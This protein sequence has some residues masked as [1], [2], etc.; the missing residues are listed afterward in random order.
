MPRNPRRRRRIRPALLTLATATAMVV[1]LPG[2]ATAAAGPDAPVARAAAPAP[3]PS[4]PAPNSV[5]IAG[6]LQSELGCAGDWQPACTAT[7]LARAADGSY[8]ADWTLPAGTYQFKVAINHSW[9]TN[10]GAGGA[11]GGDNI[12][13]VLAGP[14][15][16]TFRYDPETHLVSMTPTSLPSDRVTAQ[17]R[18]LAGTS[19]RRNSSDR[20]YFVM[21][22][23]FA[24]GDPGNDTGGYP[25]P[26]GSTPE[27]AKR[28]TGLDPTNAGFYHG[29]DLQ[30][31]INKLDYI[32]GLGSTAIWLT[33]TFKNRPVQGSGND[34]SAGYHGYWITDFTQIDPHLGSN[35]DMKRLIDAAHAKGMKVYF[36]IITNH[37]ADVI[38]YQQGAERG[39][40]YIDKAAAPYRDAAGKPFDDR[41]Y[42]AGDTFPELNRQSFPYTPQFRKPGDETV[43]VPAWLNDPLRYHNRGNAAF[44]GTEGDQYGDFSGLDDLFT[45]QPTV[46]DGMIDIY[47]YWAK[48]GVD[49]FRIDTVKHVNTE[50]WQK[51][52]P[53]VNKAAADAGK[54]DFF[55]FGEVYESDPRKLAYY[56]TTAKLPATLDFGFQ[57]RAT[58]FGLSQPTS[59]LAELYAADDYYTDT[60]SNAYALP[61][62]LGNHDM[63]RIGYFLNSGGSF[64]DT[65]LLQR[66]RLVQ[67]LMF[68]TRGQPITYYGDEQ[69]FTGDGG[70][71]AARQDMFA[72]KVAAYNDDKLIGS[73]GSTATENYNTKAPL[74]SEIAALSA[75]RQQ[76]PALSAG[77]QIPRYSSNK[78][79]VFAVSR[80]AADEQREYVVAANNADTAQQ[81][82]FGVY[83]PNTNYRAIFGADDTVR[84]GRGGQFTVTVPPLSTVVYRADRKLAKSTSAPQPVFTTAAG[85]VVGDR[86]PVGVAVPAGGF[87]QVSFAWRPAGTN[88]W[89]P[90]GVDDNPPYRV[91]PDLSGV[92]DG[93]VVE[94]RAV[95]RD[96]SGNL[97]ATSSSAVVGT[98]PAPPATGG[99]AVNDPPETQ[100]NSVT[101][102]GDLNTEMGCSGDWQPDCGAAQLQLDTA[103]G[104]WKGTFTLP[105]GGTFQYKAA[106][107]NSWT[108]NYGAGG[109][110]N[111][112]NISLTVPASGRVTFY[113]DPGS[114]VVTSDAEGPIVTAPGSAQ[115]ELGCAADW[116]PDCLR[117]W[118]TDP[119]GDGVYTFSTS[120]IPPGSYE[121][122]VAE[123]LSWDV[124]YGAG[125]EPGGANIGYTVSAG[126]VVTFSYVASTHVLTVTASASTAADLGKAKGQWISPELVAWKAGDAA[127][128]PETLSYRL[129]YAADGGMGIDRTGLTGG[130]WIPLTRDPAGLPTG[131][132]ADHPNLT[133]Y[134]ALRL[135][136]DVTRDKALLRQISSGQIA[137]AAF[138][139]DGTLVDAT[140]VQLPLL[141]DA[142]YAK[143][144]EAKLGPVWQGRVPR[145]SVW[146]PTAREVSLLVTPT[147][148]DQQSVPMR[149]GPDGVWFTVG[150]P[151][152]KNAQYRFAVTVYVPS[153]DK[154]V[155]NTVTDPYS[156]A[157]TTNSTASVL[158]DLNDP[159][160]TPSGWAQQ[161]K[162]ALPQPS[163]TS[164]YELSVR[165]FSATDPSVPEQQRGTYLAFTD[166][167]TNGMKHLRA[168][169]KAGMN[170]LHLLPAFD[171]A[172]VNEN[173][174]T[175]KNPPCDL[176]ALSAADPAGEQQQQCVGSVTESDAFNWGYDPLHYT[177]PEGSYATDP[178]GPART[179]QFRQ[180][181]QGIN[182]AGLRVVMDV[183][184]N[185]TSASGQDDK[186]VLDKLVPGYYHRL[187]AEGA[188]ETS[189]CCA[190]TATEH[191][192]M[193]KLTVDSVVTWAKQYKVD[194]FRF[195]LMGHM[196]KQT[197]LDVRAALDRLT[198][199]RDGVDGKKV[200]LY[201]EGWN[202]GEVADDA[203]FEQATQLNMGGT[204]IG[205][206]ND[207]LRD[208]VRGG[209]PFD[210]NPG[211]QGFGTG[212][213]TDPNNSGANGSPAQQRAALLADTDR[214]KVALT[215]NLADY[216]LVDAAGKLV[217]GKDIDY[218]GAPTGYA[219]QPSDTINYVD[220]HDNDTLYDALA[221]K[222]PVD[223][224]MADRVRM[225]TLSLATATLSQAPSFWHAGTD[226]LRS[227]SFD[228]NSYNS[229]DWF[230]RIDW[231]GQ[232][233]TFGSGLPL[234]AD[235]SA[236]WDYQRPLLANRSLKPDAAAMQSAT[237]QA[238]EL[239]KLRY[240]SPLFRLGNAA[241]IQQKVSF[242]TAGPSTP[243]GVIA[244]QLDDRV[245]TAVDQRTARIVVVFNATPQSQTVAVPQASGLRLSPIQAGGVDP[246]VKRS[247]VSGSSVSVPAR[248]VAVF[249]QPRS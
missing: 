146:A 161:R 18:S 99:E 210:D 29:G 236:K 36:D 130:Q 11:E 196:P 230:N 15:Q 126:S 201:G 194:G 16:L 189:T 17:D 154:V 175:W 113:Y 115:S 73:A 192:M 222:L 128:R 112:A 226:L 20:F 122:K 34:V 181:V 22:D 171:F 74:Y 241:Q 117:P 41:D 61:T 75:L 85:A 125:G 60:D 27:A 97:A 116:S 87:N 135:P 136:D 91:M 2:A 45:E 94:Y 118:L 167:D 149:R 71:K 50:F 134:Q 238:Q 14:A 199:A 248:T 197:L 231:T 49:G 247:T 213:L 53:S 232:Q 59:A 81:V 215:G 217:R 32:K 67:Q 89:R 82:S 160:L 182:N 28:I 165:D 131:V 143:A 68:L 93:T 88:Q 205:T 39:Y 151:T 177:A 8:T 46:R 48:F 184:Y 216:Q 153:L 51:F 159:A 229:G 9:D 133:G 10:Y 25:V 185:H 55:Q 86:S 170:T 121:T 78:A 173:K 233:N 43:K 166:P 249:V 206:F 83:N 138:A 111:G 6:S 235:N 44:D 240:S 12:P 155:T 132:V 64:S 214:I 5:T 4:A 80:I 37:T 169:A 152:W 26:P 163:D 234:A 183:V 168:L 223:T 191:L 124:N 245:G 172:T 105:A 188:L 1:A 100:P 164:I 30:G 84:S 212:L 92:A 158:A 239:L 77:A 204:G 187:S 109:Q 150:K 195:D 31:V 108:V 106:I 63:G 24:N 224:S 70:D 96:N 62:F 13:L 114:H 162:P 242:L 186:S 139:G 35:A 237:A 101:I 76:H 54:P 218:N 7:D 72:S 179:K 40:A 123:G 129:Y 145:V 69:G 156:V 141:L 140:G 120:K 193:N 219:E 207:R 38:D 79:G 202:F 21:T 65:E 221:Y 198:L 147:G 190:N 180:M 56:T 148:Q 174:Q 58:G 220:A 57:S 225:N 52:I 203:R 104:I 246:V 47:S 107:D 119:D 244:M 227:K 176:P 208:S 19:L 90:L 110:Q 144:S 243:P 102:A 209:S 66:D 228:G 137:I 157:L 3:A 142:L 211:K 200:Y 42:A 98:P 178:N 95:L 23:R 127:N 103:S 33:P